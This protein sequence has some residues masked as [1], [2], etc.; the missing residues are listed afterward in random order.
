MITCSVTKSLKNVLV[1]A[2]LIEETMPGA[3]RSWCTMARF[4][5]LVIFFNLLSV[6]LL[7][8][9]VTAVWR[10]FVNS[11]KGH[12]TYRIALHIILLTST[13][14]LQQWWW[15]KYSFLPYPQQFEH[16]I[17]C[18]KSDNN[19]HSKGS[20][21]KQ[22]GAGEGYKWKGG[23]CEHLNCLKKEENLLDLL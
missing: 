14:C 10:D 19:T 9:G 12:S 6:V 3:Y 16:S 20:F 11:T 23:N 4:E 18:T 17:I 13:L 15:Q 5:V 7:I 8:S 21:Q 2:I 1:W 22:R